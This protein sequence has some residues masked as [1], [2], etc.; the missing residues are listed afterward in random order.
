MVFND[1]GGWRGGLIC[2][3][4]PLNDGGVILDVKQWASSVPSQGC[5]RHLYIYISTSWA[6][7]LLV[8]EYEVYHLSVE[9]GLG[10]QTLH[11]V[12]GHSISKLAI[13]HLAVLPKKL[14]EEAGQR[15]V[16]LPY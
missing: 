13:E 4:N 2:Q 9:M 6:M 12:P 15:M 10:A 8:Q 14:E 1:S 16:P 3:L 11:Q 5:W 7:V